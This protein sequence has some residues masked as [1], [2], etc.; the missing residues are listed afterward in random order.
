MPA[1]SAGGQ[2]RVL[3]RVAERQ[4]VADNRLYVRML[5]LPAGFPDPGEIEYSP[6]TPPSPADRDMLAILVS[7]CEAYA[8]DNAED[9]ARLTPKAR[10]IGEALHRRGGIEEMR[11]VFGLIPAQPG[12]RTSETVWNGIGDWR[13]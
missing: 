2:T 11:R 7:L 8:H 12:K 13:D 10:R 3:Y 4:P 5:T 9:I 1:T 6:Y